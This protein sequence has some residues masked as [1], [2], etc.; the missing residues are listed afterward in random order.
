MLN[1]D[2]KGEEHRAEV[3]VE[4]RG[5][6]ADLGN[7]SPHCN[8]CSSLSDIDSPSKTD[9]SFSETLLR[10]AQTLQSPSAAPC[11]PC[12]PCEPLLPHYSL[13]DANSEGLVRAE[14]EI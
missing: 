4:R 6:G 13:D 5:L 9:H 2:S 7:D 11:P 8:S 12:P 14:F 1:P 10:W 3:A